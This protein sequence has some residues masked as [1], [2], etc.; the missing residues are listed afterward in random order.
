M[1]DEKN[2]FEKGWRVNG[3]RGLKFE[4][5]VLGFE[6]EGCGKRRFLGTGKGKGKIALFEIFL[7][8][9]YG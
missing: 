8:R 9:L 5:W 7:E 2:R 3:L 6:G 1:I 4:V